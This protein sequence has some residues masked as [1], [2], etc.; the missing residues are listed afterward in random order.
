MLIF[1]SL[2]KNAWLVI[3]HRQQQLPL[4]LYQ[5][6]ALFWIPQPAERIS[7]LYLH[8][9]PLPFCLKCSFEGTACRNSSKLNAFYSKAVIDEDGRLLAGR[10]L[11]K[12]TSQT[13]RPVCTETALDLV[14]KMWL[15]TNLYIHLTTKQKYRVRRTSSSSGMGFLKYLISRGT[16]LTVINSWLIFVSQVRWCKSLFIYYE[17]I[18]IFILKWE[19][20]KLSARD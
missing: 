1:F 13:S 18:Q 5:P 8:S 2:T 14:L 11:L 9:S 15:K 16:K 17:E 20:K 3:R 6:S 4:S 19:L 10:Y 12:N 7:S